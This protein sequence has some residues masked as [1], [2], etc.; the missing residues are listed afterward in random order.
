MTG[1]IDAAQEVYERM[2][3]GFYGLTSVILMMVFLALAREPRA[4]GATRLSPIDFGR[5]L[6]LDRMPEV[7]T[8]RRKL[9]ELAKRNLGSALVS[10]LALRHAKA[11][12]AQIGY[13]CATNL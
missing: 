5:L 13:G 9:A 11:H 7:K 3:N 12:P 1:L 8:I 10:S 6:G 4:Q 2:R